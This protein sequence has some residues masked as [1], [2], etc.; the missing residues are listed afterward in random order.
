MMAKLYLAVAVAFVVCSAMPEQKAVDGAVDEMS[1]LL[2]AD[3]T[4]EVQQMFDSNRKAS[5]NLP[6]ELAALEHDAESVDKNQPAD[7]GEADLSLKV[8]KAEVNKYVEQY[9]KTGEMPKLNTKTDRLIKADHSPQQIE[10]NQA[11]RDAKHTEA[12]DD[13]EFASFGKTLDNKEKVDEMEKREVGGVMAQA[14]AAL[15]KSAALNND[16]ESEELGESEH[17]AVEEAAKDALAESANLDKEEE[18]AEPKLGEDGEEA[19]EETPEEKKLDAMAMKYKQQEKTTEQSLDK[20]EKTYVKNMKAQ[21]KIDEEIS[22]VKAAAT[23]GLELNAEAGSTEELGESVDVSN[24]F[25]TLHKILTNADSVLN[26]DK[27]AHKA[28]AAISDA[29]SEHGDDL[30]E[31][32]MH[33]LSEALF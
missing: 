5:L 12:T 7:I 13:T 19:D 1:G 27:D 23:E 14:K 11:L 6:K 17:E 20:N 32:G 28:A 9:K 30:L 31:M 8:P 16:E 29:I 15:A 10:L 25:D 26:D 4:D 2:G 3:D 18:D 22:S 33:A 21:K 24:E